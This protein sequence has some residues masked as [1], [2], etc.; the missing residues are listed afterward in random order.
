MDLRGAQKKEKNCA[1]P[2]HAENLHLIL[3]ASETG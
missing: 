2:E 3:P 1:G